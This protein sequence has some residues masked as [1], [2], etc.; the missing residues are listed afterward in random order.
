MSGGIQP[1]IRQSQSTRARI[2]IRSA[3]AAPN[4]QDERDEESD[5][6][7]DSPDTGVRAREGN[8]L[9]PRTSP[10]T[11]GKSRE[12]SRVRR[13][14]SS[15]RSSPSESAGLASPGC[16]TLRDLEI[17]RAI[18]VYARTTSGRSPVWH[19]TNVS[20]TEDPSRS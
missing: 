16:E 8:A 20:S 3:E 6:R 5:R 2:S 11:A 1:R 18:L 14:V 7:L 15:S 19:C 4:H 13:D 10:P 9:A 17:G 12:T